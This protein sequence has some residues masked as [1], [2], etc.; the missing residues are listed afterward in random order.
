MPLGL[1]S[2]VGFWCWRPL[3]LERIGSGL[4]GSGWDEESSASGSGSV[5]ESE[6][7]EIGQ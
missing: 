1:E 6:L 2:G 4:L 3:P 5:S 7:N